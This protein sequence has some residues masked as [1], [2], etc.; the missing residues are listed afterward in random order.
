MN[1]DLSEELMELYYATENAGPFSLA[2]LQSSIPELASPRPGLSTMI[3]A[4]HTAI[5]AEGRDPLT[6]FVHFAAG[7]DGIRATVAFDMPPLECSRAR[8]LLENRRATWDG[9]DRLVFAGLEAREKE[10]VSLVVGQL[11]LA[12]MTLPRMFAAALK[13]RTSTWSELIRRSG[14]DRY[15][16]EEAASDL[17][18]RRPGALKAMLPVMTREV[19]IER[20]HQLLHRARVMGLPEN[21][22]S[23]LSTFADALKAFF[24][25][26]PLPAPFRA[27]LERPEAPPIWVPLEVGARLTPWQSEVVATLQRYW[28]LLDPKGPS[29]ERGVIDSV[30]KKNLAQ[31]NPIGP[32][33]EDLVLEGRMV[34]II[35][36]TVARA[37]ESNT[38]A[39]RKAG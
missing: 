31:W 8:R 38:T 11:E 1:A 21:G 26:E 15:L 24:A 22:L 16:G 20:E 36:G 4:A 12:L 2:E 23:I 29:M 3:D 33:A 7:P 32:D 37:L 25:S 17:V 30:T 34:A 14:V 10:R 19:A 28:S 9:E 39:V 6:S 18:M 13:T 5:E 27:A 35:A